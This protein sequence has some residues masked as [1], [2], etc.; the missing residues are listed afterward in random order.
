[1]IGPFLEENWEGDS[2]E[3]EFLEGIV[4]KVKIIN[5]SVNLPS[6]AC[7]PLVFEYDERGK[8]VDSYFEGLRN[9]SYLV[10]PRVVR[11]ASA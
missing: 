8:L 3:E 1:M 7:G 2:V 9:R 4:K 5:P 11:V 6:S 10:K